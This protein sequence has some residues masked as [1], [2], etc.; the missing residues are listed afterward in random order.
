MAHRGQSRVVYVLMVDEDGSGI[1][2]VPTAVFDRK[3]TI[4]ELYSMEILPVGGAEGVMELS[5]LFE[6]KILWW[7]K[8]HRYP[9]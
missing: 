5:E 8:V 4:K 6:E 1:I 2:G 7:K 3:P 9:A